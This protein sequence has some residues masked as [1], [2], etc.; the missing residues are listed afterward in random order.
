MDAVTAMV[1]RLQQVP[2]PWVEVRGILALSELD[3]QSLNRTPTLFVFNV[4]ERAAPDVRGS[5]PALQSVTLTVA[6]VCIDRVGNHGE[7]DLLPLRREIR[8]RIFGWQ[9]AGFEPFTLAGGQLLNVTS[10]QVAWIDRFVTEYTEDAN[11]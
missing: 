11:G 9:P 5:G 2:A 4:D 8:R 7:P 1:Q 6:V 10:G 3:R